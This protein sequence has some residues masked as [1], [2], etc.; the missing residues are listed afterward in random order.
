MSIIHRLIKKIISKSGAAEKQGNPAEMGER[1]LSG[2][3]AAI[4][5]ALSKS[6]EIFSASKEDTFDE[7]MTNGIRPF[8]DAV[9]LDRVVFYKMVDIEGGKRLGQVYR[10]DKSEGGLIYLADELRVL[11][12]TP[13]IEHWFAVTSKGGNVRIRESDC[14]EDQ[15]ALLRPYGIRSILL[16]PI[17]TYG[18][19]WGGVAFQDHTNDRYFDEDCADLLHSAARIFSNA[20]IKEEVRQSAEKAFGALKRREEMSAALNRAAVRFLSQREDSFEETMTAGVKEIADVFSL[21][22]FS[23]LR[24]LTVVDGL[25]YGGQ[26]YR[27][28]R[29]SGG[30]TAPVQGLEFFSPDQSVPNWRK[31]FAS[32]GV[33]NGPV[34]LMPEAAVLQKFG[35]VS[36][37]VTPVFINNNFWGVAFF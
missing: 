35:L 11:P 5:E 1:E 3:H 9:G 29:E 10:W 34:R 22:R 27:W 2:R 16:I 12:N 36:L 24:N 15:A 17:F 23:L 18:E 32:G 33:I 37:C 14:S 13:V 20:I 28:D 25:R 6:I 26:I 21:D 30:T 31:I 7:V 8:A 19:L 4:V